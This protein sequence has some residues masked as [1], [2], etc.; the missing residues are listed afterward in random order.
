[1]W[2]RVSGPH[3]CAS[4]E[5][6]RK[7]VTCLSQQSLW[8]L[9]GRLARPSL[10]CRSLRCPALQKAASE[11]SPSRPTCDGSVPAAAVVGRGTSLDMLLCAQDKGTL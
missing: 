5:H 10:G 9:G 8:W 2:E 7:P 6:C 3:P 4:R 11:Q 1:M